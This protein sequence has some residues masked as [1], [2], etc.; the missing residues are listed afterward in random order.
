MKG[1]EV[2][3]VEKNVKYSFGLVR[4]DVIRLQEDI[5]SINKTLEATMKALG[6][7]KIE[8]VQLKQRVKELEFKKVEKKKKK[9]ISSKAGKKFHVKECP[10]AHKIKEEN[11]VI[12]DNRLDAVS[13]AFT[14]CE[15]AA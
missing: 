7:L 2:K 15:C 13:E 1:R 6:D 12:F 14:A 5:L 10:F 4:D 9:Y 11:K 8:N 3:K